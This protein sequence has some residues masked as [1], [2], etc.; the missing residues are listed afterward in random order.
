MRARHVGVARAQ[1]HDLALVRAHALHQAAKPVAAGAPPASAVKRIM[2]SSFEMSSC[3]SLYAR[4][5]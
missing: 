4:E 1:I 2:S 3:R 5:R